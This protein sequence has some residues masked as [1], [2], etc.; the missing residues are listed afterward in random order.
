MADDKFVDKDDIWAQR[1]DDGWVLIHAAYTGAG[2][3]TP[4][5][6]PD[7]ELVLARLKK[8]DI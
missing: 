3:V 2:A 5:G 7:R 1:A 4:T 6:Q 8:G